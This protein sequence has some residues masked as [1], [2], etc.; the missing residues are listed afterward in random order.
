VSETAPRRL[1]AL[2]ATLA[3]VAPAL[4]GCGATVAYDRA[5]VRVPPPPQGAS[6]DALAVAVAVRDGRPHAL[7]EPSRVGVARSTMYLPFDATT[8]SARPL[9]DDAA[10]SLSAGLLQSGW[11]PRTLA[12]TPGA[13]EET[14]RETHARSGVERMLLL[15]L[16]EWSSDGYFGHVTLTYHLRLSLV[17]RGMATPLAAVEAEGEEERDYGAGGYGRACLQAFGE[18]LSGLVAQVPLLPQDAPPPGERSPP[19]PEQVSCVCGQRLEPH[20][21]VCPSCAKPTR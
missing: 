6:A 9:G 11:H 12:L 8:E 5:L 14:V 3:T 16:L 21:R 20:W 2:L 15:E 1:T 7:V 4:A 19:E 17:A 13:A 18:V 10:A